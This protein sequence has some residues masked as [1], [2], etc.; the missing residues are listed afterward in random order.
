MW[1][2]MQSVCS[3]MSKIVIISP[4]LGNVVI[5]I[6]FNGLYGK[7]YEMGILEWNPFCWA[8]RF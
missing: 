1:I 2:Q 4:N 6:P 5:K 8:A 3:G 7:R